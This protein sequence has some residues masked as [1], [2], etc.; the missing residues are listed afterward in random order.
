MLVLFSKSNSLEQFNVHLLDQQ[1]GRVLHLAHSGGAIMTYLAARYHLTP[2]ETARIDIATF[3]GGRSI[4]RKYFAGGR[5]VNYYAHNDPVLLLD[6]RASALSKLLN[7]TTAR[8]AV[9]DG[10][11]TAYNEIRDIK[12]NTTFVF[13]DGQLN[14]PIRDHDMAGPTYITALKLEAIEHKRRMSHLSTP[15]ETQKYWIRLG[16]KRAA[17]L[18][19]MHHFWGS[20]PV[21]LRSVRKSS[22]R[23]SNMHG[24]FNGSY[25]NYSGFNFSSPLM[26]QLRFENVRAVKTL[27]EVVK[28]SSTAVAIIPSKPSSWF[29]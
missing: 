7:A 6:K 17:S 23:I 29:S 8:S 20:L 16:R 4:T 2:N 22:A 28:S 10:Q 27:P 13:L 26:S 9:T 3:G 11:K 21:L 12:H 24:F 5:I 19:G 1:L 15:I 25:F 14:H 18:T